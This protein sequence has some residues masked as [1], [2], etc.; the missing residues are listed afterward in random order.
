[1]TNNIQT[2]LAGREVLSHPDLCHIV[3]KEQDMLTV[4]REI[5][6]TVLTFMEVIKERTSYIA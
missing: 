5:G 1:M 3:Q 2:F 4:V 6:S